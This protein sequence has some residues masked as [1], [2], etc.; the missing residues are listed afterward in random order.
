MAFFWDLIVLK[1]LKE[2]QGVHCT[3]I[4]FDLYTKSTKGTEKTGTKLY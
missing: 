1:V 4:Y 2:K 3:K